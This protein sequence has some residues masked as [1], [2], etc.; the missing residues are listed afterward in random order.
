MMARKRLLS[1]ATQKA[2]RV[3]CEAIAFKNGQS[4]LFSRLVKSLEYIKNAGT[5]TRNTIQLSQMEQSIYEETGITAS[6]IVI[7]DTDFLIN[8][9]VNV[10]DLDRNN[11]LL[12]PIESYFGKCKDITDMVGFR[13]SNRYGTVD[14]VNGRVSGMFSD[15]PITIA[16][17]T[18]CFKS[19]MTTFQKVATVILH[20]LGHIYGMF[21]RFLDVVVTT[22]AAAST[23]ERIKG[24]VREQDRIRVVNEFQRTVD[25]KLANAETYIETDDI[26]VVYTKLILDTLQTR[27]NENGEAYYNWKGFEFT[28]DQF[29]TRHGA[30][31][32]L[33]EVLDESVGDVSKESMPFFLMSQLL[34]LAGSATVGAL[35]GAW[36]GPI[37]MISGA[38]GT[39]A[40][41]M[42]IDPRHD[43]YDKPRDRFQRIFNEYSIALKDK[44][45]KGEMREFYLDE[46]RKIQKVID[47]TANHKTL[48]E[49]IWYYLIP[50]G[51]RTHLETELQQTIEGLM[52]NKLY[53]AAA[54]FRG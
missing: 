44:N 36:A 48:R 4:E 18:G 31:A 3:G 35:L 37:G 10:P 23:A 7:P 17:T 30:G 8:A 38:I 16:L 43:L 47:D 34:V 22:M 46:Q 27:R 11:V 25:V 50:G 53:N 32:Y 49:C 14:R 24:V 1:I 41:L 33:V 20:E 29:A 9:C 15:V 5:Y 13:T 28:A 39:I 51:N 12:N 45:L 21:E 26:G 2:L 40:G 6:V 19:E 54:Q 42:A 52:H